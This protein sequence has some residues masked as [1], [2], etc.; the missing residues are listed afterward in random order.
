M[1]ITGPTSKMTIPEKP[2]GIK[3]NHSERRSE[4]AT[5]PSLPRYILF[6]HVLV[7]HPNFKEF[8]DYS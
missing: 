2:C 3:P 5:P 4:R 1:H 6:Y 7:T 8:G